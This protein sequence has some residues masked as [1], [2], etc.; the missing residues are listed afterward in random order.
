MGIFSSIKAGILVAVILHRWEEVLCTCIVWYMST[1]SALMRLPRAM[2]CLPPAM[3][4]ALLLHD[5][6]PHSF[7][8]RPWQLGANGAQQPWQ[9]WIKTVLAY[10]VAKFQAKRLR[11]HFHHCKFTKILVVSMVNA[12]WQGPC[13]AFCCSVPLCCFSNVDVVAYDLHYRGF[14]KVLARP[15]GMMPGQR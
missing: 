11:I 7:R 5:A 6:L 3:L 1:Y 9:P 8:E 15:P 10:V 13:F 2:H 14:G 12:A 4:Y